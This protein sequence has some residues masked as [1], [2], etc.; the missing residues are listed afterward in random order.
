MKK[1]VTES[2][3]FCDFCKDEEPAY[4][5]CLLCNK[6]LCRDHR[7]GLIIFLSTDVG[8]FRA[9][10][11]PDCAKPLRPILEGFRGKTTTER[12]AG[13]NPEFNEARLA[14]ILEFLS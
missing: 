6:D 3:R 4:D 11:C 13:Q 9:S 10:L 12:Q 2:R 7:V 1:D 14:E 8:S 5:E